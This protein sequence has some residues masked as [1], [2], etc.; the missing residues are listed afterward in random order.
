MADYSC[1]IGTATGDIIERTYS[2][3]SETALR[4]ELERKDLLVVSIRKLGGAAEALRTLTPF[5]PRVSV[6]EFLLF[7][8]ELMALIKAGLPI[9][10]SM[11]ILI[12]R[13]KNQVFKRALTDI[14]NRVKAGESLSESFLAQGDLFPKIYCS[15]LASGER[16]G[17]IATVLKRY[18]SYTRTVVAIRKKVVGAMIYPAI[19]LCLS[20]VLVGIL[21]YFVL[22]TFAEFYKGLG[23]ANTELP[24]LT[25]AL[26]GF[27]HFLRK[28]LILIVLGAVGGGVAFSVWKKTDAGRYQF[29]SFRL[30]L[31]LIGRILQSYAISRFARTLSTLV[32]G[33]IPLVTAIEITAESVGNSVFTRALNGVARRVKEGEAMWESIEQT[34][35]YNDMTTEMIK[36]GESTGSL[37]EMLTNISDFLDEEIDQKL[38][39]L[40]ALVEPIMLVF[41]AV[42][43]GTIMLAIYYPLL[44]LYSGSG[45]GA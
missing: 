27:S 3:D 4:R 33:G 24:W 36:V 31:P 7:N 12:E 45:L 9:L 19:L 18:V 26:V 42:L 28:N 16:S 20:F 8:Q 30:H 15:S 34:G 44:K 38:S 32:S 41:M 25:A 37:E 14:R 10:A 21:V 6:K 5:R 2:A 11:D 39:T 29:D 43:V 22:P 35:L 23:G 13:R 40:V 1:R 17:E